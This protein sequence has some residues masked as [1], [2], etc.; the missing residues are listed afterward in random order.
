MGLMEKFPVRSTLPLFLVKIITWLHMNSIT[1][2][3]YVLKPPKLIV[4]RKT[5]QFIVMSY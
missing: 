1:T 3:R 5:L 2:I 4:I